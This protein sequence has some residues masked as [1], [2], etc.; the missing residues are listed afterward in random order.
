MGIFLVLVPKIDFENTKDHGARLGAVG[1]QVLVSLDSHDAHGWDGIGDA[2]RKA[3]EAK[4]LV[5]R[6]FYVDVVLDEAIILF[7]IGIL[8]GRAVHKILVESF[9]KEQRKKSLDI[10]LGYVAGGDE[11][12]SGWGGG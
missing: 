8:P 3:I 7:E 2:F 4:I 1:G 5:E 12:C 11:R 6:Y 9:E 10:T